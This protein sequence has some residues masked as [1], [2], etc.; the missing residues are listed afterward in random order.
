MAANKHM[1]FSNA[2]LALTPPYTDL[3]LNAPALKPGIPHRIIKHPNGQFRISSGEAQLLW[4]VKL[5]FT[6]KDESSHMQQ[7]EYR[8]LESEFINYLLLMVDFI[9]RCMHTA[10]HINYL[11]WS[12]IIQRVQNA[13]IGISH[14]SM[15]SQ[16]LK[17][18]HLMKSG[19]L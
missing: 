19:I 3:Q 10:F 7:A 17:K 1:R 14:H 9:T 12:L 18:E 11:F 13:E 2:F 6:P 5:R 15:D 4:T 16:A 8:C